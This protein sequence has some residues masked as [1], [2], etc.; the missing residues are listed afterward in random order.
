M[1][2][3]EYPPS[4]TDPDNYSFR[5]REWRRPKH[6][7][8]M[9]FDEPGRVLGGDGRMVSYT[10]HYFVVSKSGGRT[11]LHVRHGG[12]DEEFSLRHYGGDIIESLAALS[13]D[14]RYLLL[15][16]IMSAHQES[17][18]RG[19]SEMWSDVSKAFTEGR[20][21]KR[22]VR[23]RNYYNVIIEPEVSEALK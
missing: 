22:K 13:S 8:E 11:T 10:S 14:Q 9:V 2:Q 6:D 19:A 18:Q 3:F 21:K 5:E 20:L 15:H 7:G 4:V 1:N 12:G 23:G 16:L 17:Y